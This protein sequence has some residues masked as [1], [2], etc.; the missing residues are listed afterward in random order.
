M[1]EIGSFTSVPIKDI[2]PTEHQAFTPWLAEN[3]DRLGE[4]LDMEFREPAETEV[5][6]GPFKLDVLAED[7]EGRKVA[8]ENQFGMTNHTHLGQVLTY[9]AGI[10]A[11]VV[12]WLV[13]TFQPEHRQALEWLNRHTH[14]GIEF[15][16]VQLK[17]VRID[18]SRPAPIFEVVAQPNKSQS[19]SKPSSDD[20]ERYR[21]FW[22]RVIDGLIEK[23]FVDRKK[24]AASGS[25]TFWSTKT[26]GGNWVAFM[27]GL[28]KQ[29]AWAYIYMDPFKDRELN[30]A[31]FDSLE[32][33]KDDIQ[34]EYG[35]ELKWERLKVRAC[36]ISVVRKGA[37]IRDAE[38]ELNATAKWIV[39]SLVRLKAHVLQPVQTEIAAFKDTDGTE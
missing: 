12:V 3:I 30:H 36:R 6:I 14:D 4:A 18:S 22:Q 35:G 9:A 11:S 7:A 23:Q 8:I 5:S 1:S 32:D 15:Y 28:S 21:V 16:A 27:A 25:I 2:W 39:D 38:P 26:T 20:A 10:D 31:V 19:G 24:G 29:Q 34:E 33:N 13:E 37:S 17:A